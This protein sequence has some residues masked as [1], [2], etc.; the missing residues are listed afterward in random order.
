MFIDLTDAKKIICRFK[1]NMLMFFIKSPAFS[2]L[3]ISWDDFNV[4]YCIIISAVKFSHTFYI[5]NQNIYWT[6]WFTI[7]KSQF[8]GNPELFWNKKNLWF[9]RCILWVVFT[10]VIS[11]VNCRKSE[12]VPQFNADWLASLRSWYYFRLCVSSSCSGFDLT[13]IKKSHILNCYMFL[14]KSFKKQQF[15]NLSL[16]VT[17]VAQ[18][19]TKTA[20]SKKAIR[21]YILS[22]MSY[23]I[24]KPKSNIVITSKNLCFL[25]KMVVVVVV[26]VRGGG[27]CPPVS[28][29]L[30]RVF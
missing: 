7:L 8:I 9:L 2:L 16:L 29:A 26:V 18:F 12:N 14:Q 15:T 10:A 30:K 24:N 17:V 21:I 28:T 13:V 5:F 25:Q 6:K 22:L 11:W 19:T 4:F 20:N 27:R 1:L 3:I 23:S